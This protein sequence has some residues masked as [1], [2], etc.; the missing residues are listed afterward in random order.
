MG[1]RR[2]SFPALTASVCVRPRRRVNPIYEPWAVGSAGKSPGSAFSVFALATAGHNHWLAALVSGG[3]FIFAG[4]MFV[5]AARLEET[6]DHNT[7]I[8][9]A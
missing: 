7:A 4:A 9:T 1:S 5:L 6:G 8:T 3:P 2:D